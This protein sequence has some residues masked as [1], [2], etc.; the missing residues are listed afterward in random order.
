MDRNGPSKETRDDDKSRSP[1]KRGPQRGRSEQRETS[2]ASALSAE[3]AESQAAPASGF[4]LP[5]P[6]GSQL[7][8]ADLPDDS[9]EI[10][11]QILNNQNN[12]HS[13]LAKQITNMD[14]KISNTLN[15]HS[16]KIAEH[17]RTLN[18]FTQRVEALEREMEKWRNGTN[19]NP[20]ANQ[21]TRARSVDARMDDDFD[22]TIVRVTANNIVGREA[23]VLKLTTL[24]AEANITNTASITEYEIRPKFSEG[25]K[26]R[27]RFTGDPATAKA[28]ANQFIKSLRLPGD[29]NFKDT[30]IERPT[31]GKEH[32]YISPDHSKTQ[33]AKSGNTKLLAKAILAK[34]EGQP[35]NPIPRDATITCRWV[36]LVT[37]DAK[38]GYTTP[39]WTDAAKEQGLRIEGINSDFQE[40]IPRFRR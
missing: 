15:E 11:A 4:T 20:A 10:W 29:N 2:M 7:T 18:T 6:T 1:T 25:R 9:R 24:L 27:V 31:G 5:N 40:A 8:G 21:S 35:I 22:P 12:S 33:L 36:T 3:A 16:K 37:L 39:K 34:H 28:K 23:V 14:A 38:D 32:L 19:P 13:T 30:D 26:Y 17:G